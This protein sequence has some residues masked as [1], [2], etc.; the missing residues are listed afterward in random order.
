M[1]LAPGLDKL[2]TH[3]P[4][5]TTKE[6]VPAAIRVSADHRPLKPRKKKMGQM[7]RF[8]NARR[9]GHH[10]HVWHVE[11][12]LRNAGGVVNY[13]SEVVE[14]LPEVISTAA[15]IAGNSEGK[16]TSERR[17]DPYVDPLARRGTIVDHGV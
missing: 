17:H 11:E 15:K 10:E 5:K 13:K 8:E 14:T 7:P 16:S 4:P 9:S 2:K 6:A 12:C 3:A 1:L